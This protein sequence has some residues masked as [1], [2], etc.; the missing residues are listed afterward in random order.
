MAP[1]NTEILEALQKNPKKTL[2]TLSADELAGA[3]QMASEHYYNSSKPL[4]SDAL[5]DLARE[6]LEEIAPN[7]PVLSTIGAPIKGEKVKIPYWM[8]SLDKIKDDAKTIDKWRTTYNGPWVISDKLDGNS[9]LLVINPSTGANVMYSRGD[10][11]YGQDLSNILKYI[12][13]PKVK[14]ICAVRGELIISKKN[15]D[16]IK[17]KGSNAR[18]VVAGALHASNPDK[19]IAS[20]IEFVVY[21]LIHPK[22]APSDGLAYME[23]AGFN[24]VHNSIIENPAQLTL[25]GLSQIL[26]E[27]RNKSPYEIDG[28]VVYQDIEH[29]VVKGKN[30]KY[31]FAFK[32]V[33]TQEEAE[34][35]VS[36][37]EWSVSKHGLIK[38]VVNFPTVNIGG[39]KIKRATGFNAAYIEA[40]K[41]GPGAR[42]VIIRSGDVIPYIVRTV[43]P[44]SNGRGALPE[45]IPYE[46]TDTHI[47]IL[48][49]D[50]TDNKEIQIKTLEGFANKLDIPYLGPG[51]IAKLYEAGTT[52]LPKLMHLSAGDILK[53]EGFQKTSAEK[54][55][56][57][58]ATVRE[59]ALCIDLMAATNIFGRGLGS[60]K[61]SPVIKMYPDILTQ[62]RIPTISEVIKVEGIAEKTAKLFVDNLPA[63]FKLMDDME[64]PCRAEKPK[65]TAA[66]DKAAE[67]PAPPTPAPQRP[68]KKSLS[69]MTIVFT[70]FRNKEWEEMLESVGGKVSSAVSKNTNLVVASN[71]NDNTGKILK[72]N[73]LGVP[74]MSKEQFEREYI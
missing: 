30:P 54:L 29:K 14:E 60:R 23:E 38:P 25:D 4:I 70:G 17:D 22:M 33:H 32:S 27:R 8:G 67:T 6:H 51:T 45:D 39:V 49:K 31:A 73:N 47:D 7:H 66:K 58:L 36:T 42:I 74:V 35:T 62:R 24:V 50:Q 3:L 1:S 64:I 34:V 40:N 5:F 41:I 48:V 59:T 16:K 18:N 55:A 26:M 57:F 68:A 12:K 69:G 11:E 37:V 20:K 65:K 63:F 13:M 43:T 2:D 15:W 44:A 72:A 52:S 28:I 61:L 71:P 56:K 53:I 10:G 46:W 9:G 19:D 21:E